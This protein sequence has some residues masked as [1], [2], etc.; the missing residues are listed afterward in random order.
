VNLGSSGYVYGLWLASMM[1]SSTGGKILLLAGDTS[2]RM[3]SPGDQSLALLFADAGTATGVEPAPGAGKVPF[4]LGSDGS[5]WKNLIIP[6]GGFRNPHTPGTAVRRTC[7]DGI[8]RSDEDFFMDGAEVFAFTLRRVPPLVE[9]I[10]RTAGAEKSSIDFFIFHQANRF[11]LEHLAKKMK[12]PL[13]KVIIA[14]E[15]Y[16]N[17]SSASIPLAITASDVRE[18]IAAGGS[19]ALL[20]GFGPGFSWGATIVDLGSSAICAPIEI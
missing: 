1:A 7:E 18:R 16:G 9:A 19:R 12:V 15:Q 2:S 6:A 17:T 4:E 10:L 20:G 8:P 13:E 11:I 5:G 14:L 3:V